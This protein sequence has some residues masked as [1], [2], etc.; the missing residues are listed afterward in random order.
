MVDSWL[1][2]GTVPPKLL[3]IGLGDLGSTAL[4]FLAREPVLGPIVVAS[5]NVAR[6]ERRVNLARLGA[7]AQGFAASIRFTAVDLDRPD[8]VVELV[9]RENPDIILST[10]SRQTWWLADLLPP[11]RA[12]PLRKARFGVWLPIQ[13]AL[14][15]KLMRALRAAEYRGLTLTAPFPDV[16]NAVLGKIGLAPDCGVGN[17]D[18]IAAKVRWLAAERLGREIQ[19]IRV[20]LVAHHALE[21]LAFEGGTGPL[22][23]Y[24]LRLYLGDRDVTE[25]AGGEQLLRTPYAITG[26]AATNFLTAGSIARMMRALCS[27]ESSPLHAPAPGGLPGGYPVTVRRAAIRV[28]KIE[29]LS[30]DEAILLNETSHRWE[31]IERIEADG[32]AVFCPEDAAV[33]RDTLGYDV[34]RLRPEEADERAEELMARLREFARKSGV[35]LDRAWQAARLSG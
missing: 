32:T 27:A 11:Q 33:L 4:E 15:L 26:G 35:D 12:A 14:T 25:A 23:P 34:Q 20:H 30:L 8:T 13:L 7:I 21:P 24:Y 3:L 22:P 18:E 1:M 2:T 19:D 16:V 5:R 9:R 6:G 10:A 17:V 31:G 28:A 29:G